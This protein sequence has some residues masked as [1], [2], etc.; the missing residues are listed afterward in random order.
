[1]NKTNDKIRAKINSRWKFNSSH[2]DY[3]KFAPFVPGIFTFGNVLAGFASLA[4]SSQGKYVDAAFLIVI[5]ALFDFLDGRIAR[6]MESAS[7]IGIQLDSLADFLTFGI[8]PGFLLF[9]IGGYGFGDWKFLF[10]ILYIIAGAFRL[11]RYNILARESD[12]TEFRG[13]PIPMAGVLIAAFFLFSF[14]V[15]GEIRYQKYYPAFLALLAWLMISN[16]KYIREIIFLPKKVW[17]NVFILTLPIIAILY[18]PKL[19]IFPF[20]ALYIL[21]GLVREL[22]WQVVD[23]IRR[24]NEFHSDNCD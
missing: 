16:V 19:F 14:E 7:H 3:H 11:A 9:S 4:N 13:L 12:I 17:L 2:K 18:K 20:V 1:M 10:P 5:G 22:Y 8:A 6:L 23:P 21:F 24:R 15:W